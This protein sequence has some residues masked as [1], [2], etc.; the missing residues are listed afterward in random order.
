MQARG[1]PMK[2]HAQRRAVGFRV[3]RLPTPGQWDFPNVADTDVDARPVGGVGDAGVQNDVLNAA[4]FFLSG[5]NH[6]SVVSED[7]DGG[8]D[9]GTSVLGHAGLPGDLQLA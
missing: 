2:P 8:V 7:N 5:R 1:N 6:Q 9:T 4:P 3:K